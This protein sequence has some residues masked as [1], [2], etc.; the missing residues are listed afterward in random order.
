MHATV[1]VIVVDR[2]DVTVVHRKDVEHI[3]DMILIHSQGRGENGT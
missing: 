1:V 2:K 3:H